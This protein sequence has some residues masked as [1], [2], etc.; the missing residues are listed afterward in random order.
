MDSARIRREKKTI[1]A[2][3]AIY[4]RAHHGTRGT[5]CDDCQALVDYAECRLDRCPFGAKKPTC[6]K[7]PIHC[8]KPALREKA[9]DVMRYAGPRM[10]LRHPVLAL[11]HLLDG[12]RWAPERK[13]AK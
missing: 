8:Y 13:N 7:C 9:R 3:V 10:L 11:R 5:L 6:A 1:R 2:M 12:L 4:C